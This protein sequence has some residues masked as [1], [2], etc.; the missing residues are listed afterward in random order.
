MT[1]F[2]SSAHQRVCITRSIA[3]ELNGKKEMN[4]CNRSR[5]WDVVANQVCNVRAESE[6]E[7]KSTRSKFFLT[8][9]LYFKILHTH[10]TSLHSSRITMTLFFHIY[11]RLFKMYVA[12]HFYEGNFLLIAIKMWNF[13]IKKKKV[14]MLHHPLDWYTNELNSCSLPAPQSLKCL[15]FFTI[16]S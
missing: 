13:K 11:M 3:S 4:K 14:K 6:R 8:F 7:E 10:S 2:F 16:N 9:F 1:D 12:L 5:R 15:F